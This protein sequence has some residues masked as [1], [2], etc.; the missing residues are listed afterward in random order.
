MKNS[1]SNYFKKKYGMVVILFL[2]VLVVISAFILNK[3]NNPIVGTWIGIH[4][5]NTKT[6]SV[7]MANGKVKYYIFGKL[8]AIE[9]YKLSK[10]PKHCGIDESKRL[11]MYPKEQILIITDT[12]TNKKVCFLVYKL[13]ENRFIKSPYGSGAVDTLKKVHQ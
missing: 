1:K 7:Y 8:S 2:M 3:Q 5:T 12:K 13:T 11:E 10:T 6:R 4:R 9:K